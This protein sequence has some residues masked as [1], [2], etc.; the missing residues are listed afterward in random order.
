MASITADFNVTL[1]RSN[2]PD[3]PFQ[4]LYIVNPWDTANTFRVGP[5]VMLYVPVMNND[6]SLPIVG[7][8][9]PAGD[10]RALLHYFYG[11]S[12]L[13]V[14]F[15]DVVVDGRPTT[16]SHDYVVEVRAD[17]PLPDGATLYQT[18]AAF[19]SPLPPGTHS[20]EIRARGTGAALSRAD[21]APYFP[22]GFFEFSATYTVIV[23]DDE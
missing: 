15:A 9:P 5:G 13:G 19:L 23:A 20:V 16:L 22:G 17:P 11:Q 3:V 18:V 21:V 12:E 7:D 2:P 4:I 8:F 14:V 6:N 10:R 1:P